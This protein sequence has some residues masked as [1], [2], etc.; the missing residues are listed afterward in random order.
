MRQFEEEELKPQLGMLV[1]DGETCGRIVDIYVRLEGGIVALVLEPPSVEDCSDAERS[2]R[3]WVVGIKHVTSFFEVRSQLE[4]LGR[5][6]MAREDRELDVVAK[7][8]AADVS[9]RPVHSD[10]EP[11]W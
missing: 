4:Q 2:K 11:Q 6:S 5:E 8:E 10:G 9:Y 3:R 7:A 1:S